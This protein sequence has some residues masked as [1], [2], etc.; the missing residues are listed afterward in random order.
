[1][2]WGRRRKHV[3]LVSHTNP[4]S[5]GFATKTISALKCSNCRDIASYEETAAAELDTH[6]Q[7][8]K[9]THTHPNIT[10]ACKLKYI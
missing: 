3:K 10:Y 9:H 8:P 4:R 1:M 6:A 2:M 5:V 7:S